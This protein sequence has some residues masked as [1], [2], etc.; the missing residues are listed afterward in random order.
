[1]LAQ[2]VIQN[3]VVPSLRMMACRQLL[4]L[5]MNLVRCLLNVFSK[6]M[7]TE[8]YK[9]VVQNGHNLI[10]MILLSFRSCV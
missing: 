9:I 7:A 10:Q 8:K 5:H 2:C 3:E 1:M 6:G 4:L